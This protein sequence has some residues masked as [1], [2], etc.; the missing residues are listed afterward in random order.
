VNIDTNALIQQLPGRRWFGNKAREIA[1]LDIRDQA[2]IHE[3]PP[4]L[5]AAV[6]EI[7]FADGGKDLYHLPLLI[8][9]HGTRDAFDEPDKLAVI[10]ELMAH[11]ATISSEGGSFHF[12][13]P[14]LDPLSPPGGASVRSVGAE[15][16]NTSVVLDEEVIVKLFRRVEIGP[17]PD[18]ELNRLLTN[19]G[20]EYIPAHVGEI[21]YEAND[22][23]ESSI[24]L[25]FA[26]QFVKDGIEGWTDSLQHI[27]EFFAGIGGAQRSDTE[28]K[29]ERAGRLLSGLE[30]L[31]HVTASLHVVLA[32]EELSAEFAPEPVEDFDL[33][34]WA[35]SARA[36]LH[37]LTNAGVPELA[38]MTDQID[39]RIDRLEAISDA[40]LKTRIHGDYHLG[41][42]MRS[43]RGWLILDFEGEPA[44][45]LEERR[46]KQSPLKDVAGMLRS[47]D[48]AVTAVMFELTS[49]QDD[50]W[51]QLE[52]WARELL[53]LS[54]DRF[55]N[56]YLG[57]S[58][59][60]GFL[61]PNRDELAE[62]LDF[63][64]IDKALYEISYELG[65]RPD[66]LR[67]PLRGI[68]EVLGSG[69]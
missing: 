36:S 2:T 56:A 10:G 8:D 67:I 69:R 17:N 15:Q 58:H 35:E 6:A 57:T 24:D 22:D 55:L 42:V 65:H 30:D 62:L 45:G 11:G 48:Y 32:R 21:L 26:Q 23:E 54:R 61:P 18:L 52:P 16:S 46:A 28:S 29:D 60:G 53:D 14:G 12:G 49:P 64:E 19:E 44:R 27:R 1:S 33:K 63:F 40:G 13:G 34:Q 41:Q 66:W 25:G 20:F 50:E 51:R 9:E 68:A 43:T 37:R 4:S 39:E 31:G 59:E 38:S 5:V 3:G 7:T 47:F